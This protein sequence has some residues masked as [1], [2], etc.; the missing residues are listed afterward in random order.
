MDN[1]ID[2]EKYGSTFRTFEITKEYIRIMYRLSQNENFINDFLPIEFVQGKKFVLNRNH[3]IILYVNNEK[4]YRF[5]NTGTEYDIDDFSCYE[6]ATFACSGAN[7]IQKVARIIKEHGL[8]NFTIA[9]IAGQYGSTSQLVIDQ[10]KVKRY[11]IYDFAHIDLLRQRFAKY[12]F[13][14]IIEGDALETLD[15]I[16]PIIYDVVFYD[17]SHSYDTDIKIVRKLLKHIDSHS[18]VIFHDYDMDQ[19]RK[20]IEEFCEM[21]DGTVYGLLPNEIIKLR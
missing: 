13:V 8:E 6:K 14:N 11:D 12:D 17:C 4:Q 16:D 19:V 7:G 21:F 10:H 1:Y 3:I 2:L 15:T 9:E 20:M 5:G 18:I